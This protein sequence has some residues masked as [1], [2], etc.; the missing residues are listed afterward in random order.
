MDER[1]IREAWRR[2]AG[3]TQ[4]VFVLSIQAQNEAANLY[5]SYHAYIDR[6]KGFPSASIGCGAM[7]KT[8]NERRTVKTQIRH[9]YVK[10]SLLLVAVQVLVA[11]P[12]LELFEMDERAVILQD[13]VVISWLS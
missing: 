7:D 12:C 8:C 1:N 2:A 5:C 10:A 11:S 9:T 3:C 6:S 4:K 13:V